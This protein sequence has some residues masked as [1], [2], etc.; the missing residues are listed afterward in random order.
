MAL[1]KC[2]ECGKDVSDTV[3]DC[4][5]CGYTLKKRT[6][7]VLPGCLGLIILLVV[8]FMMAPSAR[9]TE[10][11][12]RKDPYGDEV[13]ASVACQRFVSAQLKAPA[14]AKFPLYAEVRPTALGGGRW[15][16]IAYVDAQNG[17]GATIRTR[18]VCIT[19]KMGGG[20]Y[21]EETV[22]LVK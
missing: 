12:Y 1:V 10:A 7:I 8:L 13:G 3:Q 11:E 19:K 4:P 20:D 17:F 21:V 15:Q 9:E 14:T 22:T 16:W 18:F 2:P 5:Q 6:S